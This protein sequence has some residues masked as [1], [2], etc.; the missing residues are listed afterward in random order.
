MT[1]VMDGGRPEFSEPADTGVTFG[2]FIIFEGATAPRCP[3]GRFCLDALGFGS[4]AY[5]RNGF[6][7]AE[8]LTKKPVR[9]LDP[10]WYPVNPRPGIVPIPTRKLTAGT[11]PD[12]QP[13]PAPPPRRPRPDAL[14]AEPA[15][16]AGRNDQVLGRQLMHRRLA[17]PEQR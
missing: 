2:S 15:G 11:E 3:S 7:S 1:A 4:Q 12:W 5:Y 14:T 16:E 9:L 8:D 13:V 10:D 6:P 17:E